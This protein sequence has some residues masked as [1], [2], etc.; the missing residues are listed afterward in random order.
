MRKMNIAFYGV[1]IA[2][3]VYYIYGALS[4]GLWQ[5]YGPG[6][7]LLPLLLGICFLILGVI[8]LFS[9]EALK[10]AV[11]D[12]FLTKQEGHRIAALTVLAF[13]TVVLMNTAGFLIITIIF[14]FIV[15]KYF[16]SYTT[17]KSIITSLALP[18]CLWA[19][20]NIIFKLDLPAGLLSIIL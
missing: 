12:I 9:Q 19:L 5:G 18:I 17:K 4:F 3:A 10:S 11:K 15:L 8:Q 16:E 7:G 2:V 1:V 13:L 6:P 14:S 20:F